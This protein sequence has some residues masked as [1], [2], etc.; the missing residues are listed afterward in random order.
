MA[1]PKGDTMH[2]EIVNNALKALEENGTMDELKA[3]WGIL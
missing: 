2:V 3:K 1:F